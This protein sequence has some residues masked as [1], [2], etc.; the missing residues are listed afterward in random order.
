MHQIL[1][2]CKYDEIII[3]ATNGS[4]NLSYHPERGDENYP[5]EAIP[6]WGVMD[7]VG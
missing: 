2:I 6:T 3:A 1:K 5:Q 7:I 4:G